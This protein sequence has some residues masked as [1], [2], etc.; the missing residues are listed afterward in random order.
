MASSRQEFGIVR[1]PSTLCAIVPE[2]VGIVPDPVSLPRS[3]AP[4]DAFFVAL[5]RRWHMPHFAFKGSKDGGNG[6]GPWAPHGSQH[7]RCAVSS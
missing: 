3:E 4:G 1:H 6:A 2:P 5:F 7:V